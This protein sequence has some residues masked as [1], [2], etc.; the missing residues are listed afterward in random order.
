MLYLQDVPLAFTIIPGIFSGCS[1]ILSLVVNER[2]FLV[3]TYNLQS[4]IMFL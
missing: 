1:V 3:S 4:V 2:N